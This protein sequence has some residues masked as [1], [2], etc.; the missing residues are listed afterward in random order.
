MKEEGNPMPNA[1]PLRVLIIDDETSFRLGLEIALKMDGYAPESTDS[2]ESAI[3][4]LKSERYDVILLDYSMPG[5]TGLDFLKWMKDNSLVIPVV[6]LTAAG[7]ESVAVEAMKAGAFDYLRKD[8]ADTDVI[9]KT[10]RSVHE[11]HVMMIERQRIQEEELRMRERQKEL[12]SLNMFQHTVNSI[13]LFVENGL[14][15]L[16]KNVTGHEEQLLQ[17]VTPEGKNIVETLFDELRR[18]IELVATGVKSMSDLSALVTQKLEG[19]QT[20]KSEPTQ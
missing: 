12:A 11:R 18:G 6:M 2:S 3:S 4:L 7:S 13:G 10:V 16:S 1:I 8:Q 9:S 19:L 15:S 20:E 14:N 17:Y 5:M